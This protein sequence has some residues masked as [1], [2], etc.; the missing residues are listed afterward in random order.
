M[1]WGRGGKKAYPSF[2]PIL[3]GASPASLRS[4][5]RLYMHAGEADVGCYVG[6]VVWWGLSLKYRAD[7]GRCC[8]PHTPSLHTF[9]ASLHHHRSSSAGGSHL[10]SHPCCLLTGM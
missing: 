7:F 3:A 8:S 10:L 9:L 2:R 4:Q 1:V 6:G 5:T